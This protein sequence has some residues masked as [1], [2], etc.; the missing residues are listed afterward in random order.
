MERYIR[1]RQLLKVVRSSAKETSST[2]MNYQ[3]LTEGRRDQ[4]FAF[5]ERRISISDIAKTVQHHR[6]TVYREIK[7]GRKDNIYCLNEAQMLSINK[8]RTA[9][10]YRIPKERVDFIRHFISVSNNIQHLSIYLGFI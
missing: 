1:G 4:I 3:Q 10:K 2:T 9:R 6:S 5:L 7:R 8:L